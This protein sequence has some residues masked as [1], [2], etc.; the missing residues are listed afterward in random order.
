VAVGELHRRMAVEV[1]ASLR[2]EVEEN[3]GLSQ[4]LSLVH[5]PS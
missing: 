4:P 1:A 2:V 5:K 3:R